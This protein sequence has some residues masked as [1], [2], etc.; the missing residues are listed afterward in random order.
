VKLEERIK[1][2]AMNDDQRTPPRENRK[3]EARA[4]DKT[5]TSN[6]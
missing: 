6:A 3:A 2:I 1:L 5:G 4:N